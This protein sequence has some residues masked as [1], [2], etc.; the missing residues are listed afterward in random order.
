MRFLSLTRG[1]RVGRPRIFASAELKNRMTPVTVQTFR[2]AIA[3]VVAVLAFSFGTSPSKLLAAQSNE[4]Y[5]LES[6]AEYSYGQVMRF[7]LSGNGEA[8]L[9][10]ATLFF[11]AP[12]Q[13]NTFT[14]DLPTQSGPGI[15][16]EHNLD[17]TQVRLEPFTTVSYWWQLQ[18]ADGKTITVPEQTIEYVDDQFEWRELEQ[19]GVIIHW[20]GDDVSVGQAAWD[21]VADAVPELQALIPV[22][23]PN[24]LRVYVYPST[25]DLRAGLRLSGRDWIGAHAYP[26]LGV[27]LVAASNAKTAATDLGQ[28]NQ[29]IPHE[30]SHLLL[31]QATGVGYAST[32]RWLDEGLAAASEAV[33][34]S[35]YEAVLQAAVES[36][37]TI[38][39]SELCREFPDDPDL[40][41][42]AYA[43]SL[44]LV[45]FIQAEHGN[46]ALGQMILALA[47]GASCESVTERVLGLALAELNQKWLRSQSPKSLSLQVWES[48]G[49]YLLLPLGGLILIIVL[50]MVSPRGR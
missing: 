19:D 39:F 29:S 38:P 24:P 23:M 33:P 28:G 50:L 16:A 13:P 2:R 8:N 4:N 44:S 26:Q 37:D 14:V 31:F 32:P 45:R 34:D 20:T 22:E 5:E 48:G 25:S 30:L 27:I 17:L 11:S 35:T 9:E 42:L 1:K 7:Y 3:I 18:D 47:D 10:K 15:L 6:A 43:Q 21:V 41:P 49:I 40:T 46:Q 36:A 12:G